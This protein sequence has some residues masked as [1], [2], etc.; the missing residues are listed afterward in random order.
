MVF[1]ARTR[2]RVQNHGVIETHDYGYSPVGMDNPMALAQLR[3]FDTLAAAYG[4]PF[5]DARIEGIE[6][7]LDVRFA[8]DYALILD[9]LV[10]SQDVDPNSDVNVYLT[11]QRFGQAPET[12]II[13]V[14]V[15]QSA[16]GEKIEIAFEPGDG[17]PARAAR[18]EEPRADL[19][20]RAH[21]LPGDLARGLDQ[22]A[23]P[24]AA[25]SA[26]TSCAACRARRSTRCSSPATATSPRRFR[27]TCAARSRCSICSRVRR[28]SPSTFDE[29]H[30]DESRIRSS[31]GAHGRAGHRC[32]AVRGRRRACGDHAP[33][34]ARQRGRAVRGQARRHRRAV[35][36]RGRAQRR[37]APHRA[38]QRRQ[39]AQLARARRRQRARRH[40]QRR[41]DLQG[42]RRRR[43]RVRATPASC[44]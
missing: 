27:P 13:T 7:D 43:Q 1:E 36:R 24:G 20:Q 16:A 8:Q 34:F 28:A 23:E 9:A 6:V 40:R 30:F 32:S 3:L 25:S 44:S 31:L 38:R 11:L 15:P 39:R 29:S 42:R 37:H 14:H 4:N 33:V 41:Q 35:E 12:K 21:G 22:A 5:E 17:G 19:R 18:A 10:P 2:V 26:V